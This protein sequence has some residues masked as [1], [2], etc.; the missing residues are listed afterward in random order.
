MEQPITDWR[1]DITES[2]STLKVLDGQ[3]V[4][5]HFKDEGTRRESVDY[6][7]SIA[8]A[9]LVD[10][11]TEVKTWYVKANNYALLSQIKQLGTLN[12]LHVQITRVGSKKSDTRYSIK[13]SD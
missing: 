6:G 13:K 4:K 11:E 10:G 8:F 12:N 7:I 3:T 1:E 5:G 9:F 2:S